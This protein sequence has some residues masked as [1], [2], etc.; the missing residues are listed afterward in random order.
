[1]PGSS[2]GKEFALN[3]GDLGLIPGLGRSPAGYGNPLQYSCLENPHGRK[4]LAGYSPWG[5]KELDMSEHLSTAHA[6]RIIPKILH[7]KANFLRSLGI[8]EGAQLPI[9][10]GWL[11]NFM[12][13]SIQQELPGDH[14]TL[15][16]QSEN[17]QSLSCI[18]L[19]VTLWIVAHQPPLTHGILQARILEWVAIPFSRRSLQPRDQIW[20]SRITGRFFTV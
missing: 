4:R 15:K 2:V 7:P 14:T 13:T 20:V 5:H 19:F 8:S 1:M 16:A 10:R 17:C 9:S 18:L 6:F 12:P 3:E 11:S